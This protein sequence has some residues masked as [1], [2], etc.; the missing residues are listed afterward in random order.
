[1]IHVISAGRRSHVVESFS[2]K[3]LYHIC[4]TQIVGGPVALSLPS[5]SS[6]GFFVFIMIASMHHN[7]IAHPCATLSQL[8]YCRGAPRIMSHHVSLSLSL[9]VHVVGRLIVIWFLL[10]VGGTG[11]PAEKLSEARRESS[12]K[13]TMGFLTL[14]HLVFKTRYGRSGAARHGKKDGLPWKTKTGAVEKVDRGI[15]VYDL[16]YATHVI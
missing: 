16:V 3:L 5:C 11:A 12:R 13:Q 7:L 14:E 2:V 1:M 8:L 4:Y 6:G 9:P 10:S 15:I